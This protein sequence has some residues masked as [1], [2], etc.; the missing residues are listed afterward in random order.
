MAASKPMNLLL[1][2]LLFLSRMRP[3]ERYTF[4]K[5][6]CQQLLLLLS[7]LALYFSPLLRPCQT[8]AQQLARFPLSAPTHRRQN[9]TQAPS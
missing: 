2:L 3:T 7:L 6:P 4:A 9:W 5:N 8:Q 1:G